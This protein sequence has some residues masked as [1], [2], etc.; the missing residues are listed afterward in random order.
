MAY[1]YNKEEQNTKA[2]QIQ[3]YLY[4][5]LMDETIAVYYFILHCAFQ[6]GPLVWFLSA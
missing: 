4:D 2:K 3:L 6:L 1:R 5:I